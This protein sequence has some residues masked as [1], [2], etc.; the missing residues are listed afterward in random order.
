[1]SISLLRSALVFSSDFCSDFVF[2]LMQ[3]LLIKLSLFNGTDGLTT[4][5]LSFLFVETRK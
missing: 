1:M 4:G 5:L 3:K 2:V